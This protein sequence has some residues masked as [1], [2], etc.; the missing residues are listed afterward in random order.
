MKPSNGAATTAAKEIRECHDWR[1][2]HKH[3]FSCG[4]CKVCLGMKKNPI[5]YWLSKTTSQDGIFHYFKVRPC[6]VRAVCPACKGTGIRSQEF[7]LSDHFF[8]REYLVEEALRAIQDDYEE[9]MS[10]Y[11]DINRRLALDLIK[12]GDGDFVYLDCPIDCDD[13]NHYSVGGKHLEKFESR[14]SHWHKEDLYEEH[15]DTWNKYQEWKKQQEKL[16][17]WKRTSFTFDQ[18]LD[19][20]DDD[21]LD[22]YLH[23]LAVEEDDDPSLFDDEKV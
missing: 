11:A 17:A 8:T 16:P 22:L 5:S 4:P 6:N 14:V 12:D 15:L 18:I 19:L 2:D 3:D 10:I 9:T 13:S 1:E 20:N 21:H 7:E 23:L